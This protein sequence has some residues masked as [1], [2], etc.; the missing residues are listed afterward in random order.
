MLL[1]STRCGVQIRTAV[2]VSVVSAT[3][4]H[5]ANACQCS[6]VLPSPC[7][8]LSTSGVIFLGTVKSIENRPWSE[9]WAFSKAYSDMSWRD[10]L[11]MFRDEVIVNFSVE[12]MY[13]GDPAR[14][15]PVRVTKFL[16]S[17]GFEYEPGELYFKKGE[18][19]L[20]YAGIYA[21]PLRDKSSADVHLQ[22]NHCSGTTLAS[23]AAEKIKAYR[24]LKGFERPLVIGAYNIQPEANNKVPARGQIVT[25]VPRTGTRL[26][27]TVQEDGSFLLAGVS[28]TTYTL[29]PTIAKG[30]RVEF[31]N[32]YRIKDRVPVNPET[33]NVRT[34]SCTEI[35]IAALPDG[36][37]AGTVINSN[38][39]PL[40]GSHVRL[41]NTND[42]TGLGYWWWGE[43]T[44]ARGN[45]SQGPIPP[46]KY[47]VGVYIWLPD[48]EKLF[49]QGRDAKP[50]LWF[51]PGVSRPDL[52]K[53]ITLGFA[54][55]RTGIQ[56]RVP[57]TSP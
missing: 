51:Y 45:F 18:K 38:G 34:D 39:K 13:K 9:F 1:P 6:G 42:L 5:A 43:E 36:K 24:T 14:E 15:L 12:E 56:I 55:H 11:A 23:Y 32:G 8:S 37:I 26:N 28:S 44:D 54:E 47:V 25:L 4:V 48:Q 22:T 52:A 7:N 57:K 50:S 46:G 27:A 19:Y 16:G 2:I 53:V 20:V 29:A 33:I 41:W 30:Y 40:S 31:G 35:E 49:L 3:L 21:G 17:C 10:R